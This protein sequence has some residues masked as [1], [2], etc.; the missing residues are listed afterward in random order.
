[1]YSTCAQITVECVDSTW[2]LS[3]RVPWQFVLFSLWKT[4][5]T[6][7]I[8]DASSCNKFFC[9]THL[10]SSVT[11]YNET[12]QTSFTLSMSLN[13]IKVFSESEILLTCLDSDI[14]FI[15]PWFLCFYP[16]GYVVGF[17]SCTFWKVK[18]V[19]TCLFSLQNRTQCHYGKSGIIV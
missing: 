12:L 15:F 9:L 17:I 4:G 11:L 6:I 7:V 18:Q 13:P 14:F 10:H 16:V 5:W 3:L 1:M 2:H 8:F 19:C